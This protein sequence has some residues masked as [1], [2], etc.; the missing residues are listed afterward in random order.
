M[1]YN[2]VYTKLPPKI[3]HKILCLPPSFQTA[4]RFAKSHTTTHV[5]PHSSKLPWN[6]IF[7]MDLQTTAIIHF[8]DKEGEQQ[9][10]FD[11]SIYY[12]L[13]RKILYIKGRAAD[14]EL[15]S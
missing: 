11:R 15:V 2:R 13:L 14:S 6:I 10:I 4:V 9:F 8:P 1:V 7:K 12:C 3:Q 5:F